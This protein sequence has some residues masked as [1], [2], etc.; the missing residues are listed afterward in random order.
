[1]P[2]VPKYYWDACAWIALIQREEGRF[3]QCKDVFEMAQAHKVEI[4]TSAFTLAEV[5]KRR[6]NP[7]ISQPVSGLEVAQDA[8][9]EDFILQDCVNLAQ[10]DVDVGT[11]ARRLLR[12]HP[13]IG[14]PQD[15]IHIATALLNNIDQL[16][17]FDR[18]DLL[19]LDNALGRIDG[20]KLRICRPPDR[21]APISTGPVPTPL[22]DYRAEQRNVGRDDGVQ[23]SG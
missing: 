9:F 7:D 11:I 1:M 18:A 21:P 12:S 8:Q 22:F 10:V 6:C 14:K 16:H 4:W 5:Y 17:T 19:G 3:E 23:Q 13:E 2:T 20:R 15:A